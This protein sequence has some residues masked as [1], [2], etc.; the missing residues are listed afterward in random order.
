MHTG[1]TMDVR[2]QS[3]GR[4]RSNLCLL[5]T[6]LIPVGWD[7]HDKFDVL[8]MTCLSRDSQTA[9]PPG[10]PSHGQWSTGRISNVPAQMTWMFW[11][12]SFCEDQLNYNSAGPNDRHGFRSFRNLCVLVCEVRVLKAVFNPL[13]ALL[14]YPGYVMA[15]TNGYILSREVIINWEPA[16]MPC[17]VITHCTHRIKLYSPSAGD[18]LWKFSVPKMSHIP[19]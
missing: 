8:E 7:W 17:D 4:Q 9:G 14:M 19:E 18:I 16:Q 5:W 15:F 13:S 3:T 2:W 12:G 6:D 11:T 1:G 10:P